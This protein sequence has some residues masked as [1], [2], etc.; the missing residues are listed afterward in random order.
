MGTAVD[1]VL[2][3]VHVALHMYTVTTL[4]AACVKV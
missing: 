2:S 3:A 1:G 4:T